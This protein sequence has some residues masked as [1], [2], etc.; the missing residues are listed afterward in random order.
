MH[1]MRFTVLAL[2]VC[3]SG[4]FASASPAGVALGA[5]SALQAPQP[6]QQTAIAKEVGAIKKI[7]GS[8]ITL[9]ADSGSDFTVSVQG[10]TKILQIEPGQTD[11]KSATPIQLADLQA[12]DRILVQGKASA[13][14]KT[15]G[16]IRIVAMKHA[17]VEAK[18]E[19][20][21]EDWDKRSVGG[22]VT[23]VDPAAGT[24][25][26]SVA[27][28]GGSK[29]L[30]VHTTNKTVFRRYAPDSVKFDDARPSA[31]DQIKPGNQLRALGT[32]N[33]DGTEL[34]A[35]Q[36]VSGAFRNIAG[37]ITSVDATAN[38]MTVMDL[39]A[40]KPVVV[41]IT[42]QSQLR[43]LAPE[44]AQRIAFRLKGGGAASG[45]AG[46]AP[47]GSSSGASAGGAG[48]D[49]SGSGTAPSSGAQNG[50]ASRA[51]GGAGAPGAAGPGGA[52]ADLQ[53]ILSRMP[54]ASIGD[55]QKGDAVMVV[56]TEGTDSGGVTAIT[57]VGGVDAILAAAPSG[58]QAMTLS[59]WSLGTGGIEAGANP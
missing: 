12:G 35:D 7:D 46:G 59:P 22:L 9:T 48:A 39:I 47:A 43:K 57:L 42:Q 38:S 41:K 16:A 28:S 54:A 36:I 10:P 6:A 8:A 31:L 33:A 17:D 14:G 30:A 24:V 52:R 40:K 3:A 51:P 19:R 15:I 11:L 18:K 13:D 1:S 44:I 25:S 32:R 20:E 56:S 53:Q 2:A 26:I 34:A 49:S 27:A 23:S 45:A 58:S 37:T 29:S 21:R 50:G 55:F 5:H 4:I